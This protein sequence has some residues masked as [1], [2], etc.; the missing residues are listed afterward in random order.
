MLKKAEENLLGYSSEEGKH[1][2]PRLVA[3]ILNKGSWVANEE[4]QDMWAGLLAS[5]CTND[6]HD[7]SNLIFINMLGQLTS[8]QAKILNFGCENA[9]KT[10]SKAGWLTSVEPLIVNLDKL[11]TI[12]GC[13]DFHRLDRELDH[14]RNLGLIGH[15]GF[16]GGFDMNSTDAEI[17]PTGLALQMYVR[18]KGFIGDPSTFLGLEKTNCEPSQINQEHTQQNNK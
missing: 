9:K 2:P 5:A 12:T 1:A 10:L 18:C 17:T 6:G 7:E 8:L 11:Q 4:V 13:V 3:D 16:G 14:L 15:S